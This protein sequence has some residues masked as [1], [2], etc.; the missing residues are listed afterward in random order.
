MVGRHKRWMTVVVCPLTGHH[1]RP[2]FSF[3][4]MDQTE[5]RMA[6][7]G[8]RRHAAELAE[9]TQTLE[10]QS[11]ALVEARQAAE[12]ANEAKSNFLANMSHE[13]RTPMTAVVGYADLMAEQGR[14]EDQRREWVGVIRRNARHLLELI[15]DIL[16]LSKIEA[17]K[18]TVESIACD[19]AQIVSDV[20]TML[21]PRAE[22]KKIS[23]RLDIEGP[24]PREMG[25]DPTRLRQVMVN[26]IGNAIKFTEVG[27]VGVRIGCDA[28]APSDAADTVG[29]LQIEVRD[30]GIGMTREHL[31]RLF[32]PFSQGDET[33]TRRFGG[34][35]L[36][37]A[38]SQRL[39]QLM[40]G[41]LVARS[42]SGM[43]SSFAIALP[44]RAATDEAPAFES[45]S[46]APL[47]FGQTEPMALNGRILI[48]EDTLDTQR[49]LNIV[50]GGA[51]ANIVIVNDGR[52][53]VQAAAAEKFD[54]ILM[55]MQMPN[56]DGYAAAR[57]L[58][59][60]GSKLPIIALTGHAMMGDR[61][62]CLAAG[63]DE[64]MT[65]P[66]DVPLLL[67]RVAR[68]LTPAAQRSRVA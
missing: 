44:V 32:Q 48:A 34:T 38:I 68:H 8:L 9:T 19:P 12:T 47:A 16:D 67:A 54:L 65:K 49:L 64:Y 29:T 24:M 23:L 61:E 43:G 39:V 21:R 66:I 6:E 25:G 33:T 52:A 41:T 18:M 26:L 35:G 57:E 7:E 17:G 42:E 58:R 50:L 1:A 11:V 10:K 60:S 51:G 3:V 4:M 5:R 13:I 55:D 14:S 59:R 15:N 40:G 31:A 2:R 37:L 45:E 27:E 22:K 36:G 30:T 62:R 20:V 28:P 53:A 63:C 56:M 46:I